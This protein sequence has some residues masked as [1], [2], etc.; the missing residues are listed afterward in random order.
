MRILHRGMLFGRNLNYVPLVP[1]S[2]NK[3][4]NVF[5]SH[6]SGLALKLSN[7]KLRFL[8]TKC[9]SCLAIID[10]QE[11]PMWNKWNYRFTMDDSWDE[12]IPIDPFIE[13]SQ[14][15]FSQESESSLPC[16]SPAS[17]CP[18]G[19]SSSQLTVSSVSTPSQGNDPDY[20]PGVY[21]VIGTSQL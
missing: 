20:E 11:L 17:P 12:E 1:C 10:I 9:F 21:S 19:L 3:L 18:D 14:Q 5:N 16:A 4:L 15:T 6:I 7:C 2:S 8:E 13:V